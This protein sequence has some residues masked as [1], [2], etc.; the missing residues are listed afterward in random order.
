M[1]R[2]EDNSLI[3]H[4]GPSTPMGSLMRQYWFPALLSSE[5]PTPDGDPVRVRLLGEDLIAFR[6]TTGKIGLLQNNCPHRGASLFFGRNE[7]GGLRCVYHGWKF[8]HDGTCVDMPNEP[9]ESDFRAKVK[10]IA[11]PTTERGG[12]VWTYMG[13]RKDPPPLPRFEANLLPEDAVEVGAIQR[14]C[15]WLQALEGDIDTSHLSFL[16]LGSLSAESV[17][18][19]T[20]LYYAQRNRAPHYA[21]LDTPAGAMYGAYREAEPGF[22]YWRLAHF[23]FPFFTMAPFGTLG[24]N[25]HLRAW[26]PIDDEHSMLFLVSPKA[27]RPPRPDGTPGRRV[28]VLNVPLLPNSTDWYGRFRQVQN[29]RNDY[30]IDRDAQRT[31]RSYTGIENGHVQDQAITESMGPILDRSIEHVGMA[32]VMI[33][34]VRRR[35]L[36]AARALAERGVTPPAVDDPDA[37]LQ[38]AGGVILPEGADWVSATADLREP[39]SEH[40][41]LDLAIG[42]G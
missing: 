17:Q 32:D 33:I 34:R 7:E 25:V 42:N 10:A 3:T 36:A 22:V 6:D 18:P 8:S 15:N 40:P 41:E 24:V 11:Y 26:V 2:P 14:E 4:T 5:L 23:L 13:P 12:L 31:H 30:L 27:N 29:P 20:F 38:R 16:H 37:Y 28:G 35:L 1:L 9:A 19:G 21:V 39:F